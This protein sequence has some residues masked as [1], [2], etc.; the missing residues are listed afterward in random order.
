MD[1]GFSVIVCCFN[2]SDLL[3]ETIRCICGLKSEDKF[4]CEV[5]IVDNASTDDTA[6]TADKLLKEF[7]CSFPY[8]IVSE[9]EPGLSFARKKGFDIAENEY[10]VYCDD[11]NRLDNN[12]LINAFEI[13]E[14]EKQIGALGGFSEAVSDSEF[15]YWFSDF[16]QSFSVGR[17]SGSSGEIISGLHSLWG[18]GMIL[19]RAAL[20]E[21]YGK[22]FK[23]L[24]SDRTGN[25]LVSGG[26][27]ELCFALRLA[28]WKIWF[29]ENLKLKHYLP[30]KRLKWE[31]LRELN[32]GF[33]RQKIIFDAYILNF[34]GNKTSQP[35]TDW[36]KRSLYL[37]KK[38]RSYGFRKILN[39]RKPC[40]GDPEIIRMEKT[41]G[42]IQELIKLR[43][44]YG[45]LIKETG[46]SEWISR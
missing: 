5:I 43:S 27:S 18:A 12:Y 23:S 16:K 15:P 37:L 45:R 17:Q 10:L 34:R 1:K 28:G 21:L 26:D 11:D 40:D 20:E 39:F 31:Y 7:K 4:S 44:E 22:G 14:N 30:S 33:G 24:L 35:E 42:S 2:S 8:K 46:R 41:I 6:E 9:P 36:K 3:E 25:K 13:L 32:R 38:M 29:D 19:R